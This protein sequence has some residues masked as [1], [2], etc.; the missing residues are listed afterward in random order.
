M[1]A[2]STPGRQGMGEGIP[3]EKRVRAKARRREMRCHVLVVYGRP[4]EQEDKLQS[5]LPPSH[6][7]SESL[8][9]PTS[10]HPL[11]LGSWDMDKKGAGL[12]WLCWS[13]AAEVWLPWR[14]APWKLTAGPRWTWTPAHLL[15]HRLPGP[16][17]PEV[18]RG[19]LPLCCLRPHPSTL[20]GAGESP[21]SH[22]R[23]SQHAG[24]VGWLPGSHI[25]CRTWR[26]QIPLYLGAS[27]YVVTARCPARSDPASGSVPLAG[28][29][30]P[31]YVP[32]LAPL[33]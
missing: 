2:G 24:S 29:P 6:P 12:S 14:R 10:L 25:K 11:L 32:L 18:S 33:V 20:A 19:P 5:S 4:T 3:Q 8:I 1:A 9:V 31:P 13:P 30:S 26:P 15:M 7:G 28:S 16:Q 23:Y 21:G 27:L 17:H 22:R